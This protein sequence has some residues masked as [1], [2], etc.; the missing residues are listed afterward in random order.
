MSGDQATYTCG[1]CGT[2]FT[3]PDGGGTCILCLQPA[4][5][6]HLGKKAGENGPGPLCATCA[7]GVDG[8]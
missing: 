8:G 6:D 7:A 1:T 4:C 5:N 2:A 3:D